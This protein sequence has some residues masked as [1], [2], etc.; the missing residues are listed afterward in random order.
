VAWLA[1]VVVGIHAMWRYAKTPGVA[2]HAPPSWPDQSALRRDSGVYTLVMFAHPQCSCTRA[3]LNELARLVS[4]HDGKLSTHV[5]FAEPE[6]APARWLESSTVRAARSMKHVQ[7]FED[8]GG[9]ESR[10]F[11]SATSGQVLLYDFEGQ[12]AFSGGITGSRGHEGDNL[13]QARLS[14]L[15][16]GVTGGRAGDVVSSVFGCQLWDADR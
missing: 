2:A 11:G 4:R 12:L 15:I 16:S 8:R 14:A 6:G 13:G 5:V 1:L 9:R 3:S 10:R 7:V